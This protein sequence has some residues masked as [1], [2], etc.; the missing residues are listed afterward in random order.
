MTG[1]KGQKRV[2]KWPHHSILAAAFKLGPAGMLGPGMPFGTG[3]AYR[4]ADPDHAV[5]ECLPR[6]R[7][8]LAL[9]HNAYH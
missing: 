6:L 2:G 7:G 8:P 4:W 3:G 5:M 9:S 1:K